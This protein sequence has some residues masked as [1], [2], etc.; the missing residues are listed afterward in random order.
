ME[1]PLSPPLKD[2][3]DTAVKQLTSI[4]KDIEEGLKV[5]ADKEKKWGDML[6]LMD[7]HAENAKNKIVLD[8]GT[9]IAFIK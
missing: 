3:F 4:S 7:K 5:L 6:S 9:Y 2:R 1:L 8:I